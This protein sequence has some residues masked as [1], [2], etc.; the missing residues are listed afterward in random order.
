MKHVKLLEKPAYTL[1]KE[2]GFAFR[3][4]LS[5]KFQMPPGTLFEPLKDT[6]IHQLRETPDI[7]RFAI[8]VLNRIGDIMSDEGEVVGVSKGIYNTIQGYCN[9][10]ETM[11]DNP[12]SITT[13]DTKY[14]REPEFT[15]RAL[16][17]GLKQ[18]VSKMQVVQHGKVF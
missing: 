9:G 13:T 7:Q 1:K 11:I 18:L 4:A 12:L 3:D 2:D 17:D 10:I 14:G 6:M 15:S 5:A 8:T 16:A